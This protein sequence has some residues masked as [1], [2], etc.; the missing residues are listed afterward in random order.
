MAKLVVLSEGFTGQTHELKVEKTTVG[1][2]DD[3]TFCIP[4]SSVSSHHCEIWLQGTD[5]IVKDL[6]STNGSFIDGNQITEGVLKRGQILRLGN[7]LVRLEADQPSG[8]AKKALDHTMVIPGGVKLDELE[9]GGKPVTFET[10]SP[11]AKK[12]NKINKIFIAIGV[13]LVLIIAGLLVYAFHMQGN[14]Q[15]TP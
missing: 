1:R 13:V 3:N 2:L 14:I 5:V 9:T 15:Q 11:F 6:D 7:V 8:P 4:E 12:S 10:D